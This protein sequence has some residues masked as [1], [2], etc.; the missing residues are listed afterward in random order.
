MGG[1]GRLT[2]ARIDY[3]QLLYRRAIVDNPGDAE[4]M[5]RQTMAILHHYSDPAVHTFCIKEK[6][7]ALQNPQN[8]KEYKSLLP[9]AVKAE[10]L[11]IFE[12]LSSVK[13]LEGCENLRTQNQNES[14]HHVIWGF[15]SK[16]QVQSPT[17]V[18]QALS[19]GILVYN[20]GYYF[21]INGIFTALGISLAQ[22]ASKACQQIDAR[23]VAVSKYQSIPDVKERRIERRYAKRK[24]AD[25][26]KEAE[27]TTYKR[28]IA[29]VQSRKPRSCKTCGQMLKG[30][31]HPRKCPL[32]TD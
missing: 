21:A 16:E 30:S 28:G 13:L 9:P 18:K 22:Y 7:S 26:F 15:A 12:D 31:G 8:P 1:A 14:L 24:T 4:A 3:F 17:A 5:S 20:R 11:P 2:Y 23:R 32:L 6:C 19:L 27:G 29:H 25:G 10:L